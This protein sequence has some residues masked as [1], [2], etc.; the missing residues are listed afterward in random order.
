MLKRMMFAVVCASLLATAVQAAWVPTGK[1]KIEQMPTLQASPGQAVELR[2]K[3]FYQLKNSTNPRQTKW[4]GLKGA[5]VEFT[6]WGIGSKPDNQFVGPATTNAKGV[7]TKSWTIPS[8]AKSGRR[9]KYQANL[10]SKRVQ[11]IWLPSIRATAY[12]YIK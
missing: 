4:E 9:G 3:V 1:V 7:A 11:G 5:A 2:A 8:D 12:L 10:L 6:A